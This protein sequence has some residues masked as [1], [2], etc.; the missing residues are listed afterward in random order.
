MAQKRPLAQEAEVYQN[1]L[2]EWRGHEGQYVL[3]EGDHVHGF[4][5]SYDDALKYGYDLIGLKPFFVKQVST[6]ESVHFISRF[7]D[8]CHTLHLL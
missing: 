8:S 7:F 5:S 3:I 2:S 4:F 1:K 6:I